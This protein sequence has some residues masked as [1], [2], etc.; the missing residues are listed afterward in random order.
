MIDLENG[1]QFAI[2][3]SG[4][5]PKIKFYLFGHTRISEEK[6]LETAKIETH[7]VLE[8]IKQFLESDAK[9]RAE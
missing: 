1:C 9:M 7:Q 3:G 5:E 8:K 4:T 2:R 6:T